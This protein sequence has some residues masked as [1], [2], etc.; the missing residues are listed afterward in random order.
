MSANTQDNYLILKEHKALKSILALIITLGAD[1]NMKK[2]G[3]DLK[4]LRA[5]LKFSSSTKETSTSIFSSGKPSKS[6]SRIINAFQKAIA[7]EIRNKKYGYKDE[8]LKIFHENIP[9]AVAF[10]TLNTL[11]KDDI[12]RKYVVWCL[13][14]P[15]ETVVSE[16]SRSFREVQARLDPNKSEDARNTLV[17]EFQQRF[18]AMFKDISRATN[19]QVETIQTAFLSSPDIWEGFKKYLMQQA[20]KD[21]RDNRDIR[22][23][24]DNKENP[25]VDKNATVENMSET[26][27]MLESTRN[28]V[29]WHGFKIL[30]IIQV[31]LELDID[32]SQK[33]NQAFMPAPPQRTFVPQF[34]ESKRLEINERKEDKELSPDD[35]GKSRDE[36][37]KS[38][39]T[40]S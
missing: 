24:R 26:L 6:V 8:N 39:H 5:F 22:D 30:E 27:T 36:P 29:H 4:S 18:E 33:L 31:P 23:N 15:L 28:L 14:Q 1:P 12:D 2:M 7:Q 9:I 34:R 21:N 35:P 17:K 10:E 38:R 32:Q 37:G 19:T 11:M 40:P 20:K 3:F 13:S 25:K 16:F